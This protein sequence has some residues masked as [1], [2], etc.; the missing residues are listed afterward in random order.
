MTT[1]SAT[2]AEV[3]EIEK[4][5]DTYLERDNIYAKLIRKLIQR[6]KNDGI[7]RQTEIHSKKL[8]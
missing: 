2:D 4:I 1:N 8:L 5:C 7:L 6:I 3:D